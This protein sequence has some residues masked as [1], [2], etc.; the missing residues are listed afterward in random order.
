VGLGIGNDEDEEKDE[1]DEIDEGRIWGNFEEWPKDLQ[2]KLEDIPR[3][4]L[5]NSSSV[6]GKKGL[7]VPRPDVEKHREFFE[8]FLYGGAS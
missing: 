6:F 8:R 2:I 7:D 3:D 4:G 1:K 5:I